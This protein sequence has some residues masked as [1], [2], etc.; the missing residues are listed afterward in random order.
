MKPSL[1]NHKWCL[2]NASCIL[3]ILC[4]NAKLH[5]TK[6]IQHNLRTC[7]II[8]TVQ[9]SQKLN[10]CCVWHAVEMNVTHTSLKQKNPVTCKGGGTAC[11]CV[12]KLIN[13]SEDTRWAM[14]LYQ[15]LYSRL[16]YWSILNQVS[17][18]WVYRHSEWNYFY[19]F[20]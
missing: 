13:C 4:T 1:S 19:R 14:Q 2:S 20:T 16:N 17:L 12:C 5:H 18:Y 11:L 9:T 7:T 3:L 10:A 6:A 15:S 8:N